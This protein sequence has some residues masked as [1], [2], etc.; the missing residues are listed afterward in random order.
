MAVTAAV[1]LAVAVG[2]A[3]GTAVGLAVG[4]AVGFTVETAVVVGLAVGVVVD[5]ALG[6]LVGV[7]VGEDVGASLKNSS[8]LVSFCGGF[9]GVPGAASG[10]SLLPQATNNEQTTATLANLDMRRNLAANRRSEKP[11]LWLQGVLRDVIPTCW[12]LVC[13]ASYPWL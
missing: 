11:V 9:S 8:R 6:S 5:I 4:V 13:S 10:I 2:F 1:S 12:S 3:V 7:A